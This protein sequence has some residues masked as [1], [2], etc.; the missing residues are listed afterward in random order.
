LY[1]SRVATKKFS[2]TVEA[3][4]LAEVRALAGPR[5]LS[6]FVNTAMRHELDRMRLREFLDELADEIGP[7]DEAMVAEAIDALTS[8][9]GDGGRAPA[10]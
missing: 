6:S 8:S 2:A 7:P 3:E 4:L 10:A 5:G 1:D 9:V